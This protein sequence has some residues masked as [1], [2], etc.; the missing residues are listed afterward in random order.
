VVK[1]GADEGIDIRSDALRQAQDRLRILREG[2]ADREID[3]LLRAGCEEIPLAAATNS[4][5]FLTKLQT[6]Y[7]RDS[8]HSKRLKQI[9]EELESSAVVCDALLPKLASNWPLNEIGFSPQQIS[10]RLRFFKLLNIFFNML[11]K[12]MKFHSAHERYAIASYVKNATDEWHDREVAAIR[13]S[14]A[15]GRVSQM[16]RCHLKSTE[17]SP[18]K[19]SRCRGIRCGLFL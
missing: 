15:N 12:A 4:A 18:S 19:V 6:S 16:S 8:I 2:G 3:E 14:V 9:S 1:A 5:R 13:S 7:C 17:L 11:F 10:S